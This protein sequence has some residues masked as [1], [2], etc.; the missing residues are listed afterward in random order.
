MPYENLLVNDYILEVDCDRIVTSPFQPRRHFSEEE[1]QELAQSILSIGLI[2]PPIVRQINENNQIQYQLVAG[3]RRLRAAQYAGLKSIQV[4]VRQADVEQAAQATLIENIQRVDLNPMEMAHAFK[5]LIEIFEMTQENLA[6]K[7]GKKRSTLANYLRLLSLPSDIQANLSNNK[8][9]MGHAKVILSLPNR[10]LQLKL[11]DKIMHK[12]MTVRQA[13]AACLMML[14]TPVLKKS[15]DM[16]AKDIEDQ[17]STKFGTK[18]TL[19]H[20]A[21]KGS[22]CLKIE[23]YSL[24]DLDRVLDLIT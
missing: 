23:Y 1:L 19:E 20:H 15:K 6:E 16:Y 18:V 2:H 22:G 13:E 8:I 10:E 4:I 17:L 7:I 3:E 5:K 9:S 11:Q 21:A 12:N 24:D 14:K